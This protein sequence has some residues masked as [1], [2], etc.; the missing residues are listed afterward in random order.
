MTYKHSET[1]YD[2]RSGNETKTSFTKTLSQLDRTCSQIAAKYDLYNSSGEPRKAT[3]LE[4]LSRTTCTSCIDRRL[5]ENKRDHID[6]LYRECHQLACNLL[7]E[8]LYHQLCRV[9]CSGLI[10]REKIL[11]YGKAD[12]SIIL[13]LQDARFHLIKKQV[14]VEVKTGFSLSLSQ[15]FRCMFDN[16]QSLVLWRV[17]S[18]QVLVLERIELEPLLE[19]FMKMTIVRGK[20]L[21]ARLDGPCSH[22]SQLR[23]WSPSQQELQGMLSD[24]LNAVTETLPIA[25]DAVLRKLGIAPK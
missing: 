9:G 20:R 10:R 17:R 23:N 2:I 25:V 19:L 24:F 6:K 22:E 15:L 3:I 14:L 7:I 21:L 8:E 12:I 5:R 1:L 11:K 4:I 18:R 13:V 16:A